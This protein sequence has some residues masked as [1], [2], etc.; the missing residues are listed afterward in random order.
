M[1]D[2]DVHEVEPITERK[3]VWRRLRARVPSHLATRSEIQDFFFGED[4]LLRRHDYSVD[5]AGG[6]PA[7]QH[8]Y[9][10]VEAD[11]LRLPTKRRAF[12]RGPD[13]QAI[14]E[15]LMVSIISTTPSSSKRSL[16]ALTYL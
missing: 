7:A 4:F 12:M 9:A 16:F 2:V 11:G 15:R 1:P 10:Y 8:V 6:F 5:V 14:Q 13:G 3:E